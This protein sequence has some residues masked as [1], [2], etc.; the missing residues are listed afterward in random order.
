MNVMKSY[1][2]SDDWSFFSS[3]LTQQTHLMM[4]GIDR[5]YEGSNRI[6]KFTFVSVVV[7]VAVVV[8][9]CMTF[10]VFRESEE[11]EVKRKNVSR[12]DSSCLSTGVK[13]SLVHVFI[14]FER[15]KM[16]LVF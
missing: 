12:L 10:H 3:L 5:K 4:P 2:L 9:V 6:D 14:I 8:A 1:E 7:R 11:K 13:D 16:L 15:Q